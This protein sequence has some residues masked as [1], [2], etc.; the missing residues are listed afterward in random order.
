LSITLPPAASPKANYNIVCEA[1]GSTLYISGHL[2]LKDDGT[3]IVGAVGPNSGGRTIEEGYEA[4]RWCGLNII[5][6]L[7]DQLGDLD[8]VEKVVKV[9]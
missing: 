5:A 4:A 6:T 7:K 8:R 9:G 2:P 1:P 3:L